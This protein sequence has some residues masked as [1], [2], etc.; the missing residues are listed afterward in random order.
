MAADVQEAASNDPSIQWL[1]SL[2]IEEVCALVGE[3]AFLVLPSQCY[4]NFPR[5]IIEAFAKATPVIASRLG[6]M[7]EIVDDGRTGLHFKPGDPLDLAI[8][9][10]R[11]L[12]EPVEVARMRRAARREFNRKFTADSNY[13]SLLAIYDRALGSPSVDFTNPSVIRPYP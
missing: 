5:V 9:V 13:K 10:R 12:S 2:P 8:K 11:I 4:E 3:A 7:A 1:R 6:A